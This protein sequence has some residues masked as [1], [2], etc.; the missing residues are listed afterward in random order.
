[1]ATPLSAY[2]PYLAATLAVE[3]PVVVLLLRRRCGM[4]RSALAGLLASVV[5][6][7]GLWYIWPLV[8]SPYR[9][10]LYVVT[11]EALVVMVETAVLFAVAVRVARPR[12]RTRPRAWGLALLVSL[13]AN[14]FSCSAGFLLHARW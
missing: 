9:Y 2:L 4:A 6:H 13:A 12:Y 11:G 7:P 1:V 10:A 3:L 8:I 5:T 14:G